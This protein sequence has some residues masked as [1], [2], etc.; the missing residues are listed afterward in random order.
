VRRL[1]V[2]KD[3]VEYQSVGADCLTTIDGIV[4]KQ[5][6]ASVSQL[7]VDNHSN[8]LVRSGYYAT[9]H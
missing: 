6:Y 2:V 5:E 8:I 9:E 1:P 7:G 3:R 4:A